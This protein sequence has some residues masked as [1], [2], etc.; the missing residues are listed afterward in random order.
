MGV[1][2]TID[3]TPEDRQTVLAL[4]QRHLPGTAAWVY[5]SRAR[6]T[7]TPT[8]D[9]DLVVFATPE[10]QPQV[11]D[12]R[13]AFEESNLPFRVD[14]FVW[15]DVPESFRQRIEADGAPL[16]GQEAG[17]GRTVRL[18]ATVRRDPDG[19]C[20]RRFEE[21]LDEPVRNGIYKSKEHHGHGVKM[22]NMGELFAHPRLRAVPMRRVGLSES[23]IERFSITRGDLLFARRSLVA[24]GA[25]KCSV[26]LDVDEPTAFESSIIR[27]R[28][29]AATSDP[30]YLYYFFCSPQGLHRLDTIRRQVAVAGI[31]GRDLSGL[32]I[33]APPLSEQR[34]IGHV[35]GTLD[36]KIE[37][38]RRMNA[39]LET[40]AR[41]LFRSWFVD[42]DPVRAKM[43]GRDTGLPKEIADLFP[44]RL[45]N[46][47]VG[48]M[49][50]GWPLVPLPEL[51]D[52][53]PS[54][55][56][57]KADVAP[58]LDM[59]NMPTLGHTPDSVV[60]RSFGSGMRFA[61]GDTLVARITP[62]LE[63]GKTAYVD[64][65]QDDEIG[66][67]STEYIVMKPRSPL[68]SEFAYLLARTA[69]FREFAIR[70]M[71]GTSGRQR[72]SASALSGFSMPSPPEA[73]GV[74]F[75]H[76]AQLLLGRARAAVDERCVL[77][78]CRDALLPKLI[79]GE[80]RVRDAE[81]L[82]GAIA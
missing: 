8:S 5:G 67:G 43:E 28:P 14:L 22:V 26:V 64:F 80:M 72:V 2:A 21:L 47:E 27:A 37:M 32:E 54:R 36:D 31:T 7:S 61:N 79:S 11:G 9:L 51:M 56:L 24:E 74:E 52:V 58:Y 34:A 23:E 60:R 70:N 16:V 53:N 63:N 4:L 50:A 73:I 82:V 18:A 15:D 77:A 75:G 76:A 45:V 20:I 29:A 69:R 55:P 12:L 30:L 71:S 65:L 38:N 35:L 62:C 68:P 66:W 1:D 41:A 17:H 6:W 13:E 39:T 10:Q 59:A 25:G 3:I 19:W 46:S 81:R 40:M 44:N 48:E 49:P 42:F 33:P 57:Q 78:N